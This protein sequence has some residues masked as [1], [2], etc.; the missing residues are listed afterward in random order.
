MKRP[1]NKFKNI[2]L[3]CTTFNNRTCFFRLGMKT[4]RF[5]FCFGIAVLFCQ[6]PSFAKQ[7]VIRLQAHM[8]E[9]TQ[10]L[11]AY[12]K[13]TSPKNGGEFHS[14]LLQREERFTKALEKSQ[15]SPPAL[16]P[17]WMIAGFD[18]D[19]MKETWEG[20]TPSLFLDT[21]SLLWGFIGGIGSSLCLHLFFFLVRRKKTI[22]A[23]CAK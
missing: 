9:L 22:P 4:I 1:N 7:Y 3:S 23:P 15:T 17:L 6:L 16:F 21:A 10:I 13:T 19:I 20:Y 18:K 12:S 14:F 5:I 11:H 8:A 2:H